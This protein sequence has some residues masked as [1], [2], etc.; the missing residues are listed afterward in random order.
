MQANLSVLDTLQNAA[1]AVSNTACPPTQNMGIEDHI[2]GIGTELVKAHQDLEA[3]QTTLK[4]FPNNV[5]IAESPTC[6]C[7]TKQVS[8][9][10]N[11]STEINRPPQNH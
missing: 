9:I 2:R 6:P 4:D 1:N 5:Y 3:L 8:R 10:W 7:S 11:R